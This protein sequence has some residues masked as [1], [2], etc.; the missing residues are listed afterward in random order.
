MPNLIEILKKHNVPFRQHGEHHHAS[1]GWA[2]VDC[3]YCSPNSNRFRLGF[4]ISTGRTNCWACGS[5]N[6][7]KALSTICKITYGDAE[8]LWS[9]IA[10]LPIERPIHTGELEIPNQVYSMLEAHKMYLKGRGLKPNVIENIWGVRGIGLG[11]HLSWRLFIPIHDKYEEMVSWTTRSINPNSK[12]RY[13][14]AKSEQEAIPHKDILYGAHLARQ[15]IIIVEGPL[16]AWAIGP[17]AVATCGL[18]YSRSQLR[19]M[20][21]Y[22]NKIICFDVSREAQDKAYML[23]SQLSLFPGTTQ[24][25]VLESGSDP[26]DADPAEIQEIRKTFLQEFE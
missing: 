6:R 8:K 23:C 3:P 2:S 24:N 22:T 25:I 12:S 11:S 19:E 18:S 21:Q 9:G 26:A 13:I 7:T 1:H 4:E 5:K 10:R 14:S 20:E 17:G 15:T 16:D